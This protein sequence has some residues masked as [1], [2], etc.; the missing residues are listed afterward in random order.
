MRPIMAAMAIMLLA[1]TPV[2]AA[3]RLYAET[4]SC[5]EIVAVLERDGAAIIL[6]PSRSIPGL[7][8]INRFA[9]A[10]NHCESAE[11]TV[12]FAIKSADTNVCKVPI[13]AERGDDR[14]N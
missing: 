6:Y 13:C 10:P 14:S 4:L 11:R 2:R 9:A 8:L 7:T 1:I 5:A 3:E 12:P